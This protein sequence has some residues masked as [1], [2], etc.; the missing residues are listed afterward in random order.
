MYFE[1]LSSTLSLP[2]AASCRIAVAVNCFVI[3]PIRNFVSGVFGAPS[4]M[5][6]MP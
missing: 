4:S 3:D 5:F 6:A 2:A 1:I